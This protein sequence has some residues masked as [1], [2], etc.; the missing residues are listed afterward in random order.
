MH[1]KKHLSFTLIIKQ[2]RVDEARDER[3]DIKKI[4]ELAW[5]PQISLESGLSQL[6]KWSLQTIKF[7]NV[8]EV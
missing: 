6:Y 2:F 3:A 8:W 7:N 4:K 1:I 5:E